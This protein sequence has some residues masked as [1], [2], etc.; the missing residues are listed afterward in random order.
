MLANSYLGVVEQEV[1]RLVVSRARRLRV[2]G[3][4]IDD[5]QQQIVP[6]LAEFQYDASRSNGASRTTAMTG[7]IDRQIKAHL[8]AKHRYQKR[9]ERLQVM[10]GASA[11]GR[12][13]WP[14]HVTKPEPV[15]LRMDLAAAMSSLSARDRSI[16]QGLADGLTVKVIAGQLGCGRDTVT[17]AIVRIRE[18]FTAAGMRAWI[19]PDYRSD[20]TEQA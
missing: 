16:C 11:Y 4:E 5:L 6:K 19:D 15:D 9:I 7:V 14:D 8:R 3:D 17:R 2:S 10:S 18:V 20:D 1:P 13:V 12:P